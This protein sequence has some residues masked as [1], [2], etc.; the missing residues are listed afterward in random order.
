MCRRRSFKS[1]LKLAASVVVVVSALL[2]V[3][4]FPAN[5]AST[6][7]LQTLTIREDHFRNFDFN[8][9]YNSAGNVDWAISLLFWNN[10]SINKVKDKLAGHYWWEGGPQYGLIH[11]GD[12]WRW[13]QD[14]GKKTAKCSAFGGSTVHYR[15]YA[16][17]GDR[18][19]NQA[20]GYYILGST[21]YD[22]N[23]CY[24]GSWFGMSE[25]AEQHV[26]NVAR[27]VWGSGRVLYH[28]S[29]FGNYM[30][31]FWQGNHYWENDGAASMVIVP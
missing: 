1:N 5:S 23:E 24:W 30:C 8:S 6:N 31:C 12:F 15:V 17:P 2:A 26:T 3:A 9:T 7:K 20:W 27:G 25:R 29:G 4:A 13:D 16:P 14:S 18:M 28:W 21:H 10:A 11:N 22:V 19:Y